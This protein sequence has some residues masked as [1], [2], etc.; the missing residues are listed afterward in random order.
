MKLYK[1]QVEHTFFMVAEDDQDAAIISEGYAREA[2]EHD[3]DIDLVTEYEVTSVQEIPKNW[4]D[5]IPYGDA[6]DAFKTC[7]Q[8]VSNE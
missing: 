2:M 1:V 7:A 3:L 6:E 4:R 8:Y 5:A